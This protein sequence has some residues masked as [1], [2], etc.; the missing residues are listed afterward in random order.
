M[1]VRTASLTCE[2][3]GNEWVVLL[4]FGYVGSQ[5]SCVQQLLPLLPVRSFAMLMH[6]QDVLTQGSI[7]QTDQAILPQIAA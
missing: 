1:E 5:C 6:C 3:L 7:L 4:G 2:V